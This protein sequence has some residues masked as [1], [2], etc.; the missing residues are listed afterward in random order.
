MA[1]A[2]AWT[3][4][5]GWVLV[6]LFSSR[7]S[8]SEVVAW[9]IATGILAQSILYA[10]IL[11]FGGVPG[12]KK[13]GALD[14]LLVAGSFARRPPRRGAEDAAPA[15][16]A[17]TRILIAAS[18]C[19]F[20]VSVLDFIAQP[21]W[22][23]DALAIWGLK[24]KT[25]FFTSS[26]PRR[27]FTDPAMFW[28]H[29]EYPL[30]VPLSF[31]S[32]AA[33]VRSF[34][35]QGLA[36]LDAAIEAATVLAVF[37]FLRRRVSSLA[38]GIGALLTASCFSLYRGANAGTA[39]I[40][41]ALAFV[42]L[43]TAAL[44]FEDADEPAVRARLLLASILCVATKQEGIL[45]TIVTLASMVARRRRR[46]AG[47]PIGVAALLLLVPAGVQTAW[48]RWLTRGIGHRDYEL[49]LVSP[50]RLREWVPRLKA[51]L[52]H[53]VGVELRASALPLLAL[54]AF[55]ALTP[56]TRTDRILPVILLQTAAY[57]MAASLSF[58]GAV[59]S[60]E[61]SFVRIVMALFPMLALVLAARMGELDLRRRERRI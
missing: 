58:W 14:L 46:G 48:L 11:L 21:I 52:G 18:A 37:G 12:P 57:V 17:G 28:S 29:P 10:A 59:W 49:A 20:L 36:L 24:A 53:L 16:S 47:G 55:F 13:L 56:R 38:G 54:V 25:I 40:P 3:A 8:S 9:S 42:L 35:D 6:R 1:I 2:V 15:L 41:M 50:A 51:V 60:L 45:F 4:L 19:V 7:L 30:L 34:D 27:L 31:A 32:V 61:T 26:I 23:T 39:E 5:T 33:L 43:S 44:E 22:A